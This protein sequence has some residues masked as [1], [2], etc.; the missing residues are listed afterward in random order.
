[1]RQRDESAHPVIQDAL[2]KGHLDTEKPYTIHGFT[3]HDAANEGRLS[4]NRAGKHLN[5]ATPSWV[6]NADGESCYKSCQDPEGP[7]SV[8]FR[9]HSKDQ[10]RQHVYQQS[11]GDPENLRYNPFQRGARPALD[12]HGQRLS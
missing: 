12:D 4:V 11:G 3:T 9:L 7:H 6:V 1:M 2:A 10:A 8:Y 5:V